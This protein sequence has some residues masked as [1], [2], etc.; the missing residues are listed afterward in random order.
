MANNCINCKREIAKG[1]SKC[2]ICGSSQNYLSYYL[3]RILISIVLLSLLAA[4]SFW[5]VDKTAKAKQ[6]HQAQLASVKKQEI[7]SRV[8]ELQI[9]LDQANDKIRQAEANA[10][11]NTS[12]DAQVKVKLD[13]L[14]ARATKA[15]ERAGW[16]G[17]EN[18]RFKAKVKELND[19]ITTS[20][21]QALANDQLQ[22]QSASQKNA[23]NLEL[24]ELEGQKKNLDEI[25]NSKTDQ[26]QQ[27]WQ[28]EDASNGTQ[29]NEELLAQ[30]KQQ[31][32]LAVKN[33][34][35]QVLILNSQIDT[36]KKKIQDLG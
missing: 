16:L 13:E 14:E 28:Q 31:V 30:R 21:Q 2:Y 34:L 27:T 15:E 9:Q 26:L 4:L 25:I 11:L 20:K 10:E 6:L 19:K 33:E 8:Q 32:A 7:D 22:Q 23:L 17:R 12:T 3:N 35:D 29:P 18:R 5:Y 36:V 24:A 1:Q